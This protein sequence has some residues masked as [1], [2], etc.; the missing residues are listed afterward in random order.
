MYHQAVACLRLWAEGELELGSDDDN[1]DVAEH[2]HEDWSYEEL[3]S[4][5]AGGARDYISEVRESSQWAPHC[6]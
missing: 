2:E 5:A 1:E 3:G 6:D 4:G